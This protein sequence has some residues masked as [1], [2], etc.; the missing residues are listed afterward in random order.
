MIKHYWMPMLI[1]LVVGGCV[2]VDEITPEPT[3]PEVRMLEDQKDVEYGRAGDKSGNTEPLLLDIYFPGD[4]TTHEKY[5]LMVLI[6]GGGYVGGDK[7]GM[8]DM[9]Q[10]MTDNGFIAVSLNY[11]LGWDKGKASCSGDMDDMKR[12]M[13]F[14]LQDANAALRFLIHNKEE[15]AIDTS[16]V[17]IGGSS[18][19][20]NVALNTTYISPITAPDIFPG[21]SGTFGPINSSGN[22]LSANYSIKGVCD[23]WGGVLDSTL[24]NENNAVPQISF[25]GVKDNI[26][27]YDIGHFKQCPNY[28]F[29]YGALCIHRQLLNDQ[30]SS[31]VHLSKTGKHGPKEFSTEFIMD[32]T[33]CF[34]KSIIASENV[35][36][37]VVTDVTSSCNN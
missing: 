29:L 2:E 27:P 5:P 15:Y 19:G 34:F 32:N 22:N 37:Q 8:A 13:Y 14:G 26:V 23:M 6:H 4:A 33:V 17:F 35:S 9:C 7:N 11:R 16:W 10:I 31:V 30:T 24:I 18:A 25:H 28:I 1:T 21:L 36:S 20:G 12:A 3:T